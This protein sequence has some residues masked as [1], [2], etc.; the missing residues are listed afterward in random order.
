MAMRMLLL[1]LFVGAS[2]APVA[3]AQSEATYGARLTTGVVKLGEELELLIVVEN[4]EA[5]IDGI[6][7]VEGLEFGRL[8]TQTPSRRIE[9]TGARRRETITRSWR[10]S[11][12][13]L[14]VGDY[15]IPGVALT[16]GG[17]SVVTPPLNLSVVEDMRG[18]ELGFFEVRLSSASVVE[19]QPIEI[20][21][22]FGWDEGIASE[23]DYA[24]L[25][26]PWWGKLPELLELERPPGMMSHEATITLNSRERV[27][28]EET[29]S[30]RE[31]GRTFRTFRLRRVFLPTRSGEISLERPF[32]EFGKQDRRSIF[33]SGRKR[34][35]YFVSGEPI[36][37]NVTTLP[38]EGQP[39]EFTGA[40]GTF[41]VRAEAD[42]RDVDVG[43]SIKV[44][45]SYAGT[46]NMQFFDPPD[47]SRGDAF[48]G[49][50]VF[51]SRNLAKSL[52]RR[53]IEFDLAP[54]TD[55]VV[56]IPP[57]RL[58]VYDPELAAY[59]EV[60]TRAIPIR[61]RAL[62]D[63]VV[64]EEGEEGR[65]FS[66]DIRD[67]RSA[68]IGAAGSEDG[69]AAPGP[70]TLG[71]IALGTIFAWLT[72]RTEIRRRRG[73][74]NAPV[75]RRR[76]RARKELARE[77]SSAADDSDE[78][79]ALLRF[80]AARTREP[81]WAWVGRNPLVYL[82]DHDDP[83]LAEGGEV[84]ALTIGKLETAAYA[85]RGAGSNGAGKPGHREILTL[86]D[87]LMRGGL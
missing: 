14:G 41:D 2:F 65:G 80:L 76:R 31:R 39:V 83:E 77:L 49:F 12:R 60:A 57:I 11:I 55:D 82:S 36:V 40:I 21:M 44:E 15:E 51:G 69:L 34:E 86:A 22:L 10:V 35:T 59:T 33:G 3:A 37:I 1:L 19:K 4:A 48:K 66:D 16:V 18:E 85:G 46:G 62:E 6:P 26:L 25:I 24:N 61:V 5:E 58:A 81:E 63:E 79:R 56:E 71:L 8:R 53:T 78:L 45:V 20:E 73:D 74:P 67:V 17:Q 43:E 87:Q 68:P 9:I 27:V 50:R 52:D 64:L 70:I 23:V 72:L 38:S 28:V 7:T 84:L 75:E 54:L 42:T 13:P 47:L 29:A 32:L 30:H